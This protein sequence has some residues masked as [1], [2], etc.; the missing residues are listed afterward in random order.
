MSTAYYLSVRFR[1]VQ[2]SLRGRSYIYKT[3][4][5][6]RLTGSAGLR[7]RP[8]Q[9][10]CKLAG[11]ED[12]LRA[13][14]ETN[15]DL[16]ISELQD[17]VRAAFGITLSRGAMWNALDRLA[18]TF[19]KTAH[20]PEQDRE[21]ATKKHALWRVCQSVISPERLVFID[22]TGTNTK[23]AQLRERSPRGQRLVAPNPH[24]HWK[25]M[26][27]VAGLRLEEITAP[28]CSIAR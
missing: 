18:L 10:G 22:E 23:M 2:S 5:R 28:S 6:R 1:R 21:D 11:Y 14:V 8:G 9:P 24:G 27:F 4:K 20:A 7:P 12:V 17:W 3:Q 19:K 16:T 25:T 26:T 15:P 13:H